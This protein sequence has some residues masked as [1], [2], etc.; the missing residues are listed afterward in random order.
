MDTHSHSGSDRQMFEG[1]WKCSG[2]GTEITR[3]PFQPDPTREGGLLCR[4]CHRSKREQAQKDR[5]MFEGNWSCSRCGGQITQLPFQ[6]D[7][8][9]LDSLVCRDCFKK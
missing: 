1:N 4:D 7:P 2:C 8:N 6:P 9:R 5:P 3:L